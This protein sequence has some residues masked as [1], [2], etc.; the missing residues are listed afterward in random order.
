MK[1]YS[2]SIFSKDFKDEI[3]RLTAEYDLSS[4]G[5]FQRSAVQ[6]IIMVI[7]K[8]IA[9]GTKPGQRQRVEEQ[10]MHLFGGGGISQ[11]F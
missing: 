10:R 7:S 4:F 9:A 5:F 6:D 11:I 8:A 1:I 3:V 2:I